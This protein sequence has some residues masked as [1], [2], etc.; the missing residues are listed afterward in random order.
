MS[1]T[2]NR[3]G[4]HHVQLSMPAGQEDVGR[5]FYI[6]ILGLNEIPKPPTLAKR[7]G[8]WV[9]ADAL[10]LHLGVEHEF[11]PARKAHPGIAVADLDRLAQRL[12]D[13]NIDVEWDNNF[14]GRRRFYAPDC[15][16]NRLEFLGPPQ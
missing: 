9:R 3:F 13:N 14:P 11:R 1:S 7:G 5:R 2:E 8:F 15:W 10:E 4:L 12:T 6:E 16:G